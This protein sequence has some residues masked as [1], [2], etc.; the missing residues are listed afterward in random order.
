MLELNTKKFLGKFAA[1][2]FL[3]TSGN[4]SDSSFQR[5]LSR[6]EAVWEQGREWL[7]S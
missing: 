2:P 7:T 6:A 3:K 1:F 4:G 5:D